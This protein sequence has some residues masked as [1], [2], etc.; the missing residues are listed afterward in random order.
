M[1]EHV[2]YEEEGGCLAQLKEA[3]AGLIFAPLL[4][5]A[6]IGLLFWNEGRAVKRAQDLEQGQNKVVSLDKPTVKSDNDGGLV[7]TTGDLEVDGPVE[8]P[9]FGISAKAV[10]LKRTVEMYQWHEDKDTKKVKRNGE[11]K[12]KTTYSY[13]KSWDSDLVN[14]SSFKK[15][16]GHQNPKE[17]PYDSNVFRPDEVR[18][19]EFMVADELLEE[20]NTEKP[21]PLEKKDLEGIPEAHRDTAQ[22]RQN[23][24]YIHG[25]PRSP[26]VGDVRVNFTWIEPETVSVVGGQTDSTLSSYTS[27]K[28]NYDIGMIE[29]GTKSADKMFAEAQA[30]NTQLTWLLRGAGWLMAVIGF[31]LFF[32]PLSVIAGS[33]PMVGG[34]AEDVVETG[35]L[36]VSGLLGSALSLVVIAVGWLAY[37]PL[38]GIGLLII[39]GGCL[40]GLV[41]LVM[42]TRADREEAEAQPPA[43]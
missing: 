12:K 41:T 23:R 2:E 20:L 5:I 26:K 36:L 24:I 31:S 43:Q 14:S 15:S 18:L 42:R 27:K 4:I 28:L 25:A 38:L 30:E 6:A 19:G 10:H 13:E 16:S 40:A 32:K 7:H 33:I 34:V 35:A 8:D 11:T 17:M 1:D 29:P 22:V 37:R 21:L 39:V 9:T 3:L